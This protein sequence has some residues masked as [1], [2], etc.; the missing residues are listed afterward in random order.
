M[1]ERVLPSMS[2][3]ILGSVG[4]FGRQPSVSHRLILVICIVCIEEENNTGFS[5]LA[6]IR[7]Q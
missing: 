3:G 1:C 7:R 5:L 6:L 2:I 4:F